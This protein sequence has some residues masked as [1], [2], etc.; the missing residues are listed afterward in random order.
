[1]DQVSYYTER[2]KDRAADRE[3]DRQDRI[4]ER[5]ELRKDAEAERRRKA[6]DRKAADEKRAQARQAR[7]AKLSRVTGWVTANPARAFVRLVQVCSIVPAVVSQIGAL[8]DATVSVILAAL[9]AVMLEGSAWALVAM[10]SQAEGERSTRTY[11]LGAWTAGAIAAWINYSHG[12]QQYPQHWVA[13]VLAMSSLVAVWLTDLQTHSGKGPTRA[14]KKIARQRAA[15]AKARTEHHPEVL[16]V[17]QRLLSATPH[18]RL[19]PD[20][21][22]Q[23]AW[24]YVHGVEVPGVTADLIGHQLEAQARVAEVAAPMPLYV[25]DP[26]MPPDPFLED[27]NQAYRAAF[28]AVLEAA[29]R[30]VPG[31]VEPLGGIGQ[32]GPH[33]APQKGAAS[34]RQTGPRTAAPRPLD[35]QDLVKVRRLADAL[36]A[37]EKPLTAPEVRK[38]LGCRNEYAVRLRKAVEAERAA[39]DGDDGGELVGAH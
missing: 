38:L 29:M 6:A 22:W 5:A 32:D 13:W 24:S 27:E 9:L 15:H 36:A 31:T 18:G 25:D 2:R 39:S 16:D 17:A 11:R 26:E 23:V 12:V 14:Q 7:A 3:A 21:A 33:G 20:D 1:V 35:P 19:H 8:T 37:A 30:G 4:A 34:G 28:P 10:G